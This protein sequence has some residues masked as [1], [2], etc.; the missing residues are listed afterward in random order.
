MMGSCVRELVQVEN[1]WSRVIVAGLMSSDEVVGTSLAPASGGTQTKNGKDN[2]HEV[3]TRCDEQVEERW[4]R[5]RATLAAPLAATRSAVQTERGK[6]W[7]SSS[8]SGFENGPCQ[9]ARSTF[10]NAAFD[11]GEVL[12]LPRGSCSAPARFIDF[13]LVYISLIGRPVLVGDCPY[14]PFASASLGRH[15]ST[16]LAG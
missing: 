5:Q 16:L 8:S 14:L 15:T 11:F 12:K 9:I 1:V 6:N 10:E 4:S 7:N 3:R 13:K 2:L